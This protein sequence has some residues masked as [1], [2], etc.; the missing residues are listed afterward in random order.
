MKETQFCLCCR[1][2][3]GNVELSQADILKKVGGGKEKMKKGYIILYL[4]VFRI[5][6][7]GAIGINTY[8][9]PDKRLAKQLDLGNRYLEEM[10]YEQA[11]LAYK[12]AIEI[13]PKCEDAYLG[14]A[15]IYIT[16]EKPINAAEILEEG[17]SQTES[18][19]ILAK[20]REVFSQYP[21]EDYSHIKTEVIL[22]QLNEILA[23]ISEKEKVKE[24]EKQA[25][26]A[27]GDVFVQFVNAPFTDENGLGD[28]LASADVAREYARS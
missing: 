19:I 13:D 27:L 10:D 9:S 3:S 15:D 12:T 26:M 8:N 5:V 11:I 23:Q 7:A 22:A 16:Q 4:I 28:G 25:N 17:Y 20:L 1:A 24:D 18:E 2:E 14:L 6:F 21:K